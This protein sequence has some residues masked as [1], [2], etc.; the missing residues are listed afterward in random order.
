ML[1]ISCFV[2]DVTFADNR[3]GNSDA[4]ST[5]TPEGDIGSKICSVIY[6]CNFINA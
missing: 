2:D 6:R 5:D 4:R 3:P 1:C